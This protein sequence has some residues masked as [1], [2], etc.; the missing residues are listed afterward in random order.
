MSNSQKIPNAASRVAQTQLMLQDTKAFAETVSLLNSSHSMS[1]DTVLRVTREGS[2]QYREDLY[3]TL[4]EQIS[5]HASNPKATELQVQALAQHRELFSRENQSHALYRQLLKTDYARQH[6]VM[7]TLEA[8]SVRNPTRLHLIGLDVAISEY[9]RRDTLTR[10]DAQKL[11]ILQKLHG[12]MDR[13]LN[14]QPGLFARLRALRETLRPRNIWKSVKE[15]VKLFIESARD[16]RDQQRVDKLNKL[17]GSSQAKARQASKDFYAF[18]EAQKNA[19]TEKNL[20]A[21][22]E[23]QVEKG[24][25]DMEPEMNIPAKQTLSTAMPEAAEEKNQAKLSQSAPQTSAPQTSVSDLKQESKQEVEKIQQPAT[26]ECGKKLFAEAISKDGELFKPADRINEDSIWELQVDGTDKHAKVIAAESAKSRILKRPE[27]I[28]GADKQ[29]YGNHL[30]TVETV[31]PGEAVSRDGK[32]HITKKPQVHVYDR[33]LKRESD[34]QTEQA[35]GK[36]LPELKKDTRPPVKNTV[37]MA[38][39]NQ[40]KPLP[41]KQQ[42]SLD[43]PSFLQE[44]KKV[45]VEKARQ[46]RRTAPAPAPIPVRT[47]QP[48]V[49]LGKAVAVAKNQTRGYGR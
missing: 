49:K 19:Q 39:K 47:Q 10:Q 35:S 12:S 2:P 4:T 38:E 42:L 32:W 25:V 27:F 31:E 18:L 34:T 21:S 3:A 9:S 23:K 26:N 44:Q 29:I 36:A 48:A 46:A 6:E 43:F 22:L 45:Q 5:K 11:A 16:I 13:K 37:Q 33:S 20:V 30:N 24:F 1:D 14:P 8:E 17:T 15:G 7:A 41:R 28:N 40:P